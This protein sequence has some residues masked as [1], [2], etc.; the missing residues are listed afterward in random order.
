[1][2]RRLVIII[3]VDALGWELAG[4][5]TFAPVLGAP[6]APIR[7]VLGYSSANLPTIMTGRLPREHGHFSM[8]RRA[9]RDGVFA[10]VRPALSLA[11]RLVDRHWRI[12]GWLA[13][14]LRWRGI[15]GYF[16]LYEIPF[17][18]LAEFDLCQRRDIHAPGAFAGM[19]GLADLVVAGGAGRIWNWSV[20]EDRA[21]AELAGEIDRGEK[22]VLYLYTPALDGLM[23][24]TGPESGAVREALAG[25]ARRV[26]GL[27]KRAEKR[28]EEVRF[29]VFGDHGMAPVRGVHDLRGEL[30]SA[31]FG[32]GGPVLY[33]LDSTM[34][35]F[36]FRSAA[37]RRRIE[38]I[39]APHSWGRVL[40]DGELESLGALFPDH[41]Y[42]ELIFL[43]EEGEILVPSFMSG[44]P[45]RGM[46]GYHPDAPHS[47]TVLL[48][49]VADR[50]YPANLVELHA[51]LR[52]EI[53]EATA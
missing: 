48:S 25:Y 49:N 34:A 44:T 36:W 18:V 9:G 23:H 17:T 16:S 46:H 11:S 28:Y 5:R 38:E 3:L 20:P 27:W 29:F 8:Y 31:G 52:D 33:F 37:D 10:G 7:S 21:F 53:R 47:F 40:G 22:R 19:S 39:L 24:A 35:R 45:V 51:Y 30:E 6:R 12:S 2:T 43:L 50:P 1:V 4:N 41:R 26:E 13:S 15:T 32:V 42:G 14:W